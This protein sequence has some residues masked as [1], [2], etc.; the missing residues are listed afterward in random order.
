M[1]TSPAGRTRD[2]GPPS[3]RLAG[4]SQEDGAPERTDVVT[5]FLRHRA[6]VLLVRRSSRV[7]SYRG[8][9]GGVAGHVETED[10]LQD[11]RREIE[12][13]TGL[14][15]AV[16]LAGRG[17]PFTVDDPDAG[18][19]WRVHPFLFDV[20][21]RD[22]VLDWEAVEGEWVPPTAILERNCVPR[23]WTSYARV[24]PTLESVR[25]DR[26]HGAAYLSLRALEVLRDRAAAVA[27]GVEAPGD[28]TPGGAGAVVGGRSGPVAGGEPAR[29]D[30]D[31]L[32]VLARALRGAQPAMTALRNRLDRAMTG[33]RDACG[34]GGIAG[35]RRAAVA[36]SRA[37]AAAAQDVLEGALR[38]EDAVLASAA[39]LVADRRVLTL[40]LSETLAQALL[41]ARPAPACVAV[42][43]SRP[44]GEGQV[45]AD[46]LAAR[47]IDVALVPDAAMAWA[48]ERFDL[49]LVA[50]GA[51][52]V[53]PGGDV[54]N[55]VGTRVAALAAQASGTPFLAVAACDKIAPEGSVWDASAAGE[56]DDAAYG[57][58]PDPAPDRAADGRALWRSPLF[59]RTPAALV[60][61]VVTE[62]GV[63]DA[64]G[65]RRVAAQHARAGGWDR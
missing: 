17:E 51:D 42:A 34:T 29:T 59:E 10:P 16:T 45:L 20:S 26:Q 47:G 40:S 36:W 23:L 6:E 15:D 18:R 57:G 19:R 53:L 54:V 63:L 32:R 11:A 3:D 39:G 48:L 28:A 13:E 5:C 27:A 37:V 24:A 4:R 30:E 12:E 35:D 61:G 1:T 43:E 56:G 44:G 38:A 21:R 31:A 55:K 64:E 50:V 33:A 7:G 60:G 41:A 65:V 62:T 49:D 46:R 2:G 58:A 9:W 25:A 52:T 8:R 22:F 14:G